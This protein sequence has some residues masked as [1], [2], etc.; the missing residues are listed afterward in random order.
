MNVLSEEELLH[1][2]AL[3]NTPLV[4]D[5]TAKRL[6]SHCGSA[7]NVFTLSKQK[8]QKIDGIG[9]KIIENLSVSTH[10]KDAEK[11]LKLIE[12]Y[13]ITPIY[14]TEKNY[15][16]L[17]KQCP[18]SPILL[19][20]RGNIHLQNKR[21]I[22]IV[23]TRNVTPYGMAFCEKLVED[24]AQWNVVIVSGLA[25]GIDI[26]AHKSA[27]ANN[28]QTVA[29]LAHGLDTIYPKIHKKYADQMEQNGGLVTDFPCQSPFDRNHFLSRNRIIAG[30]SEATIV[31]E[32]GV[33][34]GSLVTADIAF[35]Y[36]RE[37]F[38]VPG[39]AT[40]TYS[41]GCNQLIRNEKAR[42]LLHAEDIVYQ[43]GWEKTDP[44]PVQNQLFP[45]LSAEETIIVSFLKSNGKQLLDAI[46]LG[47]NLPIYSV[48]NI[49]FQLEMKSV[50]RALPGKAFEII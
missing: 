30:M 14:F 6:I 37:V 40:D 12:K 5:I 24:L 47:C 31:I 35:S 19:Y 13:K 10:L 44:K 28:L 49:L 1:L 16:E 17:L 7:Q 46:S 39:R 36:N 26:T 9:S 23:G 27:L 48:S 29:C 45:E 32:S 21:I 41:V 42:I 38:A 43:L 2:I 8:L 3:K 11:E 34:G 15:P 20:Q 33:K 50:V 18:D 4:G 25:Y 22:S